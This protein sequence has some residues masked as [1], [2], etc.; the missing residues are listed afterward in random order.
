MTSEENK[1]LVRRAVQVFNRHDLDA[2]PETF[3][4][5]RCRFMRP[6]IILVFLMLAASLS[7][8]S[9]F[10]TSRAIGV[11]ISCEEF[12]ENPHSI[13]NEFQVETGDKITAK[14]CS[15]PTTGFRWKYQMIGD[16]AVKEEDHD[17]VEPEGESVVGAAGQEV[18]TFEAVRQGTTEVHM[19]YGRQWEGG[20]QTQWTYRFTVKV[21]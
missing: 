12:N 4:A 3:A 16:I 9:C 21:E 8:L 6:R 11:E 5:V 1:A 19:E 2:I 13:R 18:W 15:N 14:L 17:F 20:E 10:V 7:P